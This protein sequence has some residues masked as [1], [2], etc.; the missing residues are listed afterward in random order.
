MST[1]KSNQKGEIVTILTV[2]TLVVLSAIT[3]VSSIL[4]PKNKQT[5][6]SRA[7]DPTTCSNPN[8]PINFCIREECDTAISKWVMIEKFCNNEKKIIE[9]AGAATNRSCNQAGKQCCGGGTT[10]CTLPAASTSTQTSGGNTAT[11]NATT[12]TGSAKSNGCFSLKAEFEQKLEN[13]KVAF[14]TWVTFESATAGDVE[15]LANGQHAAGWNGFG[16][17]RFTYDPNWTHPGWPGN[18][19]PIAIVDL[20]SKVN[21]G[22]EGFLR[23]CN[24]QSITINCTLTANAN[25]TGS[26]S[27][28][29]GCVCKN[30]AAPPAAAPVATAAPVAPTTA[31][32]VVKPTI[33]TNCGLP[34]Q[35][36]CF[37]N[38]KFYC[39]N[40]NF[41]CAT[42][43]SKCYF[44][45]DIKNAPCC[46]DTTGPNQN[47]PYCIKE[48]KCKNNT[49]QPKADAPVAPAAPTAPVVLQATCKENYETISVGTCYYIVPDT[50]AGGPQKC[51]NGEIA[52]SDSAEGCMILR[53]CPASKNPEDT[54][55]YSCFNGGTQ[56]NCK[57]AGDVHSN[58]TTVTIYN[59]KTSRSPLYLWRIHVI[60]HAAFGILSTDKTLN[61]ATLDFNPSDPD[62]EKLVE[63]APD[64]TSV[65][66][67]TN[68]VVACKSFAQSVE[69]TLYYVKKDG[70]K[71]SYTG[72]GNCTGGV[73]I[74]LRISN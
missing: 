7:E 31:P 10:S 55:L 37:K 43:D 71:L 13:G 39:D 59:D 70:T 30:C 33:T 35:K 64:K 72:W 24:P 28:E 34:K 36:C 57:G 69:A 66:D 68:E 4:L 74:L 5:T 53:E 8:K 16:G 3:L 60:K 52:F 41:F 2:G 42:E 61:L 65:H 22:Y 14:Y 51:G 47:Q 25:G 21:A 58:T 29:S 54:C 18:W 49:C 12:T 1:I 26:V 45:C 27:G 11:G 62:I 73:N 44:K 32:G 67:L 46:K 56:V 63:L 15:L 17:G 50:V 48:L 40:D 6:A 9:K 20:G 23:N 38:N 19:G